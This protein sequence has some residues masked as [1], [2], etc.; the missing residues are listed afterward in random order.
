VVSSSRPKPPLPRPALILP[1]SI[2]CLPPHPRQVASYWPWR[3]GPTILPGCSY[4]PTDFKTEPRQRRPGDLLPN[5][6]ASFGFGL[7]TA[8][9]RQNRGGV[10][11]FQPVP[12]EQIH[13]NRILRDRGFFSRS[14]PENFNVECGSCAFHV[15]P[16]G[17]GRGSVG[18]IAAAADAQTS[19]CNQSLRNAARHFRSDQRSQVARIS[20]GALALLSLENPLQESSRTPLRLRRLNHCGECRM[21]D[22]LHWSRHRSAHPAGEPKY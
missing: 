16:E 5:F 6:F 2:R 21:K 10:S 7:H 12:R 15:A 8:L 20:T 19:A 3:K 11:D 9:G 22:T 18:E 17:I 4:R 14:N 13:P 1:L